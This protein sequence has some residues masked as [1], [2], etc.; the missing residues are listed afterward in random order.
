LFSFSPYKK[1]ERDQDSSS[2][3]DVRIQW[4]AAICK[5]QDTVEDRSLAWCSSWGCGVGHDLANE[6]Q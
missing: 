6:Q 5:L 4:K 1:R 2:L 3:Y